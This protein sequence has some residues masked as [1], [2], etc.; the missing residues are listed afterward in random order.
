MYIAVS[1]WIV[2]HAPRL[3]WRGTGVWLECP[4]DEGIL[5][6]GILRACQNLVQ[7]SPL[8]QVSDTTGGRQP[9]PGQRVDSEGA[10]GSLN[11]E[12]V[13]SATQA[14]VADMTISQF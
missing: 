11:W 7:L 10:S 2:G 1:G 5:S 6:F 14:C 8:C 3:I 13:M 12:I 4:T 9:R